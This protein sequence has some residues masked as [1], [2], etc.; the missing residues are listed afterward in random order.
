MHLDEDDNRVR[1]LPLHL[2]ERT[3]EAQ[4]TQ[5]FELFRYRPT[6]VAWY[7]DNLVFPAHLRFQ[8]HKL[9][10]SGQDVGGSMLFSQRIGF[11]R[12]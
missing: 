3:N 11:S 12:R 7:V 4:M 5:L 1:V 9:M 6:I 8:Q 2:L 10:A